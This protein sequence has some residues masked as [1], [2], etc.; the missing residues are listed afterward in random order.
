MKIIDI[1]NEKIIVNDNSLYNA[2]IVIEIE[3]ND[4]LSDIRRD[5]EEKQGL[6]PI[7]VEF[8]EFT[9]NLNEE[10]VENVDIYSITNVG[11]AY[12]KIK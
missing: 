6:N 2:D 10:Q 8:V 4:N 9:A 7:Y 11:M 3:S 5:Y 12:K 1:S